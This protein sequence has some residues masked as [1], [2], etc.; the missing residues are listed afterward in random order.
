[1][2]YSLLALS[3]VIALPA[4]ADNH[5]RRYGGMNLAEGNSAQMQ[6]CSLRA[7]KSEADYNKVMNGYIQWSKDNGVPVYVLRMTPLFQS[8]PPP[9]VDM[10]FEWIDMLISP[11][12]RAGEGW[13]KWLTTD[14]GQRLNDQWQATADCRVSMNT[15]FNQVIDNEALAATDTR[16]IT[17]NWCT[18]NPGVTADSLIARHDM[19]ASSRT[20][21]SPVKAWN[22]MLPGIGNRNPPGDFAHMLSFADVKGLMAWQNG[23]ANE[24]GWRRRQ[25]YYRGY[26]QCTGENAYTARVLN[27]P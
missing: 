2:K 3:L 17:F 11:F 6:L 21:D 4:L 25:E 9:N 18:V 22:I 1:M 20:D 27:R 13:D 19:M 5:E 7:R 23:M 14:S 8:P 26:A 16:V 24:G 10:A 15:L 12:G